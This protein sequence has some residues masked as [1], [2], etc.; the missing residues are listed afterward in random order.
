MS[1]EAGATD[2]E[3]AD[4]KAAEHNRAAWGHTHPYEPRWPA[5]LAVLIALILYYTLPERLTPGPTWLVPALELA[6]IVPLNLT[7]PRIT[8]FNGQ[9]AY[10]L[11][12]VQRAYVSNLTP[13]VSTGIAS[14]APTIGIVQ[15]GADGRAGLRGRP[16]CA[17]PDRGEPPE[18][19]IGP[20]RAFGTGAHATT[21][22]SLELLVDLAVGSTLGDLCDV[23]CGSGVLAIAAARLGWGPVLAVDHDPECLRAARENAVRNRVAIEVRPCDVRRQ[24]PP[25]APTMVANLLRPLLLDLERRLQLAPELLIVSGLLVEET[26]EVAGAF[27]RRLHFDETDESFADRAR[28]VGTRFQFGE[29]C[30]ADKMNRV[31]PHSLDCSQVANEGF[32][33]AAK[34]ILG[35]AGNRNVRQLRLDAGAVCRNGVCERFFGQVLISQTLRTPLSPIRADCKAA[36]VLARR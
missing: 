15:S 13:V 26:D 3:I 5:T 36:A 33:R 4:P 14:F 23:G 25:R 18:V 2:P 17:E 21:R 34:L 27:A 7:A 22:L 10:V 24:P 1:V 32:Q 11:V 35:R 9:R 12:A 30:F 20:G 31:R 6:V 28:E 29:R 19:V 8:L 16:P